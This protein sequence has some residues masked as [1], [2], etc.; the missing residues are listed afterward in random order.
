MLVINNR[1]LKW[2]IIIIVITLLLFGGINYYDKLTANQGQLEN[3]VAVNNIDSINNASLNVK[4]EFK[5][6]FFADYRMERERL[7]GRQLELLKNIINNEATEEKAR[8]AAAI[9]IVDITT[10]MEKEIQAEN[11]IKSKGYIDCVIIMQAETSTIIVQSDNLTMMEEEELYDIVGK[12]T[13]ISNDKISII[14][15]KLN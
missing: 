10:D 3:I 7:R 5:A 12:I 14:A 2:Y 6:N 9:K 1:R 13:A 11:I 8:T 4:G 15:K